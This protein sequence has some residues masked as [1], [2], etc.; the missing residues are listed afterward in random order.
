MKSVTYEATLKE[1]KAKGLVEGKA[2]GLVEGEARGVRKIAGADVPTLDTWL[3][4]AADSPTLEAV[5]DSPAG[6]H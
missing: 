6:H 3:D 4:R 1:G 2:R 5:F